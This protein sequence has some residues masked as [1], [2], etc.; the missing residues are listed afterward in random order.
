MSE[1]TVTKVE[2]LREKDSQ[3]GRKK[4]IKLGLLD[5]EDT[6]QEAEWYT[7]I[8][9][10]EPAVGERIEGEI[11]SGPYGLSF[12]K[13][14]GGGSGGPRGSSRS[15][16]ETKAIQRQHSQE[17]MLRHEANLIA[18][19]HR[20]AFSEEEMV[21]VTN[22][23]EQDIAGKNRSVTMTGNMSDVPVDDEGLPE[24]IQIGQGESER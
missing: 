7:A 2:K 3:Y 4:I 20:G 17:M 16:G 14:R 11:S 21:A 9:T 12:K 8:E 15:P 5:A 22:W 18:A 23:F 6:V 24:Q 1:Y 10:K 13:P 19:G